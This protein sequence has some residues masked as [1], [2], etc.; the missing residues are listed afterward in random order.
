M[1]ACP[2]FCKGF[3]KLWSC[4]I[5]TFSK[6]NGA[7]WKLPLF[8]VLVFEN[9]INFIGCSVMKRFC[10][11]NIWVNLGPTFW[12]KSILVF[13]TCLINIFMRRD[14]MINVTSGTFIVL[15]SPIRVFS[16][17]IS[18]LFSNWLHV[19]C[20][21]SLI[22][23]IFFHQKVSINH[24]FSILIRHL[25]KNR[26]SS[27]NHSHINSHKVS[28]VNEAFCWINF[29]L[30]SDLL[31]IML[32]IFNDSLNFKTFNVLLCN[33]ILFFEFLKL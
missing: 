15:V 18:S 13:F 14:I 11:L 28:A 21:L 7:C 1:G 22:T 6:V 26:R 3:K 23:E 27:Y 31:C 16:E 10:I 33:F 5:K 30:I 29:I 20:V 19:F 32:K 25:S 9:E 24:E 17:R 12:C 4:S 8:C 2:I